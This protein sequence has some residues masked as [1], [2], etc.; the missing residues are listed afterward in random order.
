[1]VRANQYLQPVV[2]LNTFQDIMLTEDV[3]G[4]GKT[5]EMIG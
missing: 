2:H 1:M 3:F 5:I 4:S